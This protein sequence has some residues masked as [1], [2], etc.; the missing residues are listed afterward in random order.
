MPDFRERERQ[1]SDCRR[2]RALGFVALHVGR[3]AR[4]HDL[5]LAQRRAFTA[6][7]RARAIQAE[8]SRHLIDPRAKRSASEVRLLSAKH[9]QKRLVKDV[10]RLGLVAE[11]AEDEAEQAPLVARVQVVESGEIS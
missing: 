7:S 5:Y 2:Q 4:R 10:L 6:L 9:L 1:L 8:I 11:P 3:R